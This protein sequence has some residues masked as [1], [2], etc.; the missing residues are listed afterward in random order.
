MSNNSKFFLVSLLLTLAGCQTQPAKDGTAIDK[1][2]QE[3]KDGQQEAATMPAFEPPPEVSAALMPALE[4]NLGG[5]EALNRFDVRVSNADAR[6][7]FM[8]L[9][10]G[11]P[12]NMVVHP[13]VKGVIT[14][15]LKNVTI[16]EVMMTLRD[17][18]GYE[19]N[20]TSAGFQ[21]LPVRLQSKI[22]Y[23]DYLTLQRVGKSEMSISGGSSA[24]SDDGASQSTSTSS[25]S[26]ATSSQTDIWTELKASLLSIIGEG[27]GHSITISP[28][29]GIIVVRAM[30][31]ELREVENFLRE[32]QASL[33]RQV[34]LEAKII[35]VQLDDGFESGID[36]SLIAQG[37]GGRESTFDQASSLSNGF[38]SINFDFNDFTALIDLLNTQGNTQVL[39]S[40]RVATMNNQKA[41][42]KVGEDRRFVTDV[43]TTTVTGTGGNVTN[44]EVTLTPFFDGIALDVTPQVDRNNNVTLHIHP[45]V[46][47]V[48]EDEID[49]TIDGQLQQLPSAKT[50]VREV[51]SI[52]RARSGQLI[53]IGGLMKEE[54][55]EVQSSVPGLG[56]VPFFGAAF[57]QNKQAS[58]KSELVILLKPLVVDSPQDWS[59]SMSRSSERFDEL[60]RGFHTGGKTE[61]FGN[62]AERR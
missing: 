37:R 13:D 41:V 22:F 24:S 50:D 36:W 14:L 8:G 21:V 45:S 51:D 2:Q 56:D 31:S 33:Q 18:Y 23:I 42:I 35:E 49:V 20:Q 12:Y 10:E 52:V 46:T 58:I 27:E 55:T 40:P 15:A 17:V 7:F 59:H 32:T 11:T 48:S 6:E 44:P 38:F 61:I 39:S 29:A 19:F 53:V 4:L 28:Q 1:I 3:L 25:S 26:I 62:E 16:P 57:R 9:V 54:T 5:Q 30:P 43:S 60:N 47:D 34:I